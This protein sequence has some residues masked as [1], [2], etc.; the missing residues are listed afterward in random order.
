MA[1]DLAARAT[2]RRSGTSVR[3]RLTASG[4][5]GWKTH[6]GGGLVASGGSPGSTIRVR[7]APRPSSGTADRS[8]RV[9]G[10]AGACSSAAVGPLSTIRPKYSTAVC[11]HSSL[12]IAKLWV[13]SR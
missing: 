8:A 9:Y 11:S 1:G 3:H 13:I 2:G 6:P 4:Q 12:T 10:W 5:R 7:R